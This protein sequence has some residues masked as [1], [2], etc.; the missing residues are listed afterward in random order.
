MV[1][2]GKKRGSLMLLPLRLRTE[3]SGLK[4][5]VRTGRTVTSFLNKKAESRSGEMQQ[6]PKAQRCRIPSANRRD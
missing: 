6:N 2:L 4:S 3:V 1:L 5:E